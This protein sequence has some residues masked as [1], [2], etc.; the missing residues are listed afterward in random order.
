MLYETTDKI[1]EAARD[2]YSTKDSTST[3][4]EI[5]SVI[6]DLRQ[7]SLNVIQYYNALS[8][9]WQQLDTFEEHGWE[10]LGDAQRYRWI[11]ENKRIIKFLVSLSKNLDDVRGRVLAIKPMPSIR[12]VF[13]EVRREEL[14]KRVML[15]DVRSLSPENSSALAAKGNQGNESKMKKGRPWYEHYRRPDHTHETCW[16]SHGKQNMELKKRVV[17]MQ[18][19]LMRV[20]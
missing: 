11:V 7:G 20:K 18:L 12:E 6:H 5:E 16:K 3:I 9:L 13:S 14:R 4:F 19:L 10:C 2:F 1:W 17:R 8:R 15:G